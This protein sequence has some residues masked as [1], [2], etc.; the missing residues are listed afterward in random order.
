MYAPHLINKWG[1]DVCCRGEI[2]SYFYTKEPFAGNIIEH[3]EYCTVQNVLHVQG[4]Y[5]R[6]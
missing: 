5:S 4:I 6:C 2:M 3:V 1:S